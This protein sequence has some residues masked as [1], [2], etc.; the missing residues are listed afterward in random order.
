MTEEKRVELEN[1]RL[2]DEL[3][4][5][6][7]LR[8]GLVRRLISAQEDERK[9][10]ARELHDDTSQILTTLL[11]TVDTAAEAYQTAEGDPL[12]EDMRALTVSALNGVHN[13]IF[14][15]RPTMLDQ[16]GL[17]A[18]LRSYAN[19]RLAGTGIKLA[20]TEEG[21]VRRLPWAIETA[22]FRTVQEAINNIARH[23][24][25]QRVALTFN[26]EQDLVEIQVQDDGVGFDPKEI[27]TASDPRRGLGLMSMQERV[28]AVGGEFFLDSRP[29]RGT[30]IRA[31]VPIQEGNN[32]S[33]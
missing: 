27:E 13:L 30:L 19:A 29:G 15:L 3:S 14:D 22:L 1:A 24:D 6:E 28:E 23:A 17:V 26:F 18:A 12:F 10:I 7:E 16:L 11:F 32:G 4:H 25:A 31:R 2:Y 21:R 8:G 9:R 20:C 33:N 5:K